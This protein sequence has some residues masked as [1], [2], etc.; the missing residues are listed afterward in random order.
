MT[1]GLGANV[2]KPHNSAVGN[3]IDCAE[4]G[5][6]KEQ[7]LPSQS[8]MPYF[9]ISAKE[10]IGIE[11]VS[12]CKIMYGVFVMWLKL[13]FM[14]PTGFCFIYCIAYENGFQGQEIWTDEKQW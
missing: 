12:L 7:M 9:E 5:V 11:D 14:F 1:R 4:R 13:Q 8:D 3:K 2:A 10:N 6:P